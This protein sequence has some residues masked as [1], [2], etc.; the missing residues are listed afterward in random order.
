[1]NGGVYIA[2]LLSIVNVFTLTNG[3]LVISIYG[4]NVFYLMMKVS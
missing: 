3:L 2:T 1:M 4:F